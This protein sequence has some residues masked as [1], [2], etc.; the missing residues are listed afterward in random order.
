MLRR[1]KAT[2]S[3]LLP[4]QET[5]VEVE[6]TRTQKKYYRALYQ[7]NGAAL[8][9]GFKRSMMNIAMELR[10]CCNHPYLLDSV[11]EL[12]RARGD[13][14]SLD[15]VDALVNASSRCPSG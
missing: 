9:K 6:L 10:K 7:T 14:E 4:K 15:E 12:E 3:A 8:V 2:W 1:M 11:E 5:V 13:A